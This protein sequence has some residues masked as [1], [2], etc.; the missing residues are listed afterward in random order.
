MKKSAQL[1]FESVE[2][3]IIVTVVNDL[4]RQFNGSGQNPNLDSD[5]QLHAVG[6]CW[7]FLKSLYPLWE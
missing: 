5:I 1:K 4:I 2:S 3:V 7:S 6:V